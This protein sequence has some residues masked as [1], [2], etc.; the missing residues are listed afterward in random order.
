MM[1]TSFNPPPSR[2]KVWDLGVRLFHWL[3]VASVASA[4]FLVD[5][6]LLHRRIGYVVIGLI[7]FRLV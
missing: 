1:S 7:V 2:V 6:R 5:P 3:L 4:W